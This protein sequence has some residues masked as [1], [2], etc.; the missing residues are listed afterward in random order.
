MKDG[1]DQKWC[2][3]T[4]GQLEG[5]RFIQWIPFYQIIQQSFLTSITKRCTCIDGLV[6]MYLMCK[7]CIHSS[8]HHFRRPQRKAAQISICVWSPL[9]LQ[10]CESLK[11]QIWMEHIWWRE[12]YENW[13]S[14]RES[15]KHLRF[16]KTH[17]VIYGRKRIFGWFRC[18]DSERR[19]SVLKIIHIQWAQMSPN[20]YTNINTRIHIY[21]FK[22][23]LQIQIHKQNTISEDEMSFPLCNEFCPNINA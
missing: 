15:A 13:W 5:V 16:C 6:E 9:K 7:I 17:F 1:G 2:E 22:Y 21:N 10:R 3:M 4:A 19:V 18:F 14:G 23:K 20:E 12:K 8:K 11:S